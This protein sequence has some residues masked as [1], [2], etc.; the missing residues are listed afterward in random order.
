VRRVVREA[1][2]GGAAVVADEDEQVAGAHE[3]AAGLVVVGADAE[4][5]RV[6]RLAAVAVRAQRVVRGRLPPAAVS[7][8]TTR[9]GVRHPA[10]GDDRE[11]FARS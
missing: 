2:G 7:R 5:E 1:D 4:V 8:V 9:P 3:D 10:P 11:A 6:G